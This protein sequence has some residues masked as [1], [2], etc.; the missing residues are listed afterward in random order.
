MR[1]RL[2]ID[3]LAQELLLYKKWLKKRLHSQEYLLEMPLAASVSSGWRFSNSHFSNCSFSNRHFNTAYFNSQG[4]PLLFARH[5]NR[6][7]SQDTMVAAAANSFVAANGAAT[8]PSDIH[9]ALHS[10][11]EA[12]LV[13]KP[14]EANPINQELEKLLKPLSDLQKMLMEQ[15]EQWLQNG[16]LPKPPP[17]SP[18]MSKLLTDIVIWGSVFL[19]VGF[20]ACLAW[21]YLRQMQLTWRQKSSQTTV[22][23]PRAAAFTDETAEYWLGQAQAFSAQGAFGPALQALYRALLLCLSKTRLLR[24]RESHTNGECY[25]QLSTN[26]PQLV[27]QGFQQI[28]TAFEGYCYGGNHPEETTYRQCWQT[29]QQIHQDLLSQ[30]TAPSASVGQSAAIDKTKDKTKSQAKEQSRGQS[31]GKPKTHNDDSP[32]SGR[33]SGPSSSGVGARGWVLALG[34]FFVLMLAVGG[35]F[36]K[37]RL[38]KPDGD[39][40]GVPSVYYSGQKG[41]LGWYHTVKQAGLPVTVWREPVAGLFR[42]PARSTL[43]IVEPELK[44]EEGISNHGLNAH[45]TE[46]DAEALLR[47]V[48]AGNTLVFLDEAL[49]SLPAYRLLKAVPEPAFTVSPA[50][51]PLKPP[52]AAAIQPLTDPLRIAGLCADAAALKEKEVQEASSPESQKKPKAQYRYQQAFPSSVLDAHVRQPLKGGFA[53]GLVP[54]QPKNALPFSKK[55][56]WQ[57]PSVQVLLEQ[58][59]QPVLLQVAL[60]EGRLII[61]TPVDLPSNRHFYQTDRDNYQWFTNLLFSGDVSAQSAPSAFPS[62]VIINEYV[63]G[64][65]PMPSTLMAYYNHKTPLI[66]SLMQLGLLLLGLVWASLQRWQ[67]PIARPLQDVSTAVVSSS[68]AGADFSS[69]TE[70]SAQQRFM[71]SCARLAHQAQAQS[72]LLKP[73]LNRLEFL[74]WRRYRLRLT[75][76]LDS[77]SPGDDV[78]ESLRGL[79]QSTTRIGLGGRATAGSLAT[80]AGRTPTL[81]DASAE[82]ADGLSLAEARLQHLWQARQRVL[83][84]ITLDDATLMRVYQSLVHWVENMD[85][86][87]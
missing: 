49:D 69:E 71:A 7:A 11:R 41:Y 30:L 70:Y 5:T 38:E 63:H 50:T 32:H 42:L 75:D 46:Q 53:A 79:L 44:A 19:L 55:L 64:Y 26:G 82:E 66:W 47:W 72:I 2:R 9:S 37:Y 61:G 8:H 45:L 15:F 35:Y 21:F 20:V 13:P 12:G 68:E 39:P 83:E 24:Y 52:K 33:G 3:T 16:S 67:V 31:S 59:N 29:Y 36:G 25:R 28:A 57:T 62:P 40:N 77:W 74:C 14:I 86:S 18:E 22:S 65:T 1:I 73:L 34:I 84:K 60:G 48:R 6:G 27:S 78:P 51:L 81:P 17:V 54:C 4:W 23:T 76:T 10:V 80:T 56:L 87:G 58:N 85:G 43:L